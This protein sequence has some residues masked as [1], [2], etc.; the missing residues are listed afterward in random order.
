MGNISTKP[1]LH[2][3]NLYQLLLQEVSTNYDVI[4]P[5]DLCNV[6]SLFSFCWC[7]PFSIVLQKDVFSLFLDL[8][9]Q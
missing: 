3:C 7:R 8:F 6:L 5:I 1:L 4:K 9:G 2:D